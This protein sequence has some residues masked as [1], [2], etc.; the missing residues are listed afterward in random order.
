MGRNQHLSQAEEKQGWS[1]TTE[2]LNDSLW[3]N[4]ETLELDRGSGCLQYEG[5]KCPPTMHFKVLHFAL[6]EI[7]FSL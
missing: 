3:S 1:L 7:H 2:W 6:C 4:G 5:A